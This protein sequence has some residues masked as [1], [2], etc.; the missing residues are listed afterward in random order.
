[1]T[2]INNSAYASIFKSNHIVYELSK[3]I[4]FNFTEMLTQEDAELFNESSQNLTYTE[5]LELVSDYI[6]VGYFTD[7]VEEML[8]TSL[9]QLKRKFSLIGN[10]EF[11]QSLTLQPF[12]NNMLLKLTIPSRADYLDERL[13]HNNSIVDFVQ[14]ITNDCLEEA[15]RNL[16]HN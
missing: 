14:A 2:N 6:E 7:I 13:G 9:W 12:Y 1:M 16:Y 4:S 8:S 10:S 5:Y 3:L 15:G 11:S